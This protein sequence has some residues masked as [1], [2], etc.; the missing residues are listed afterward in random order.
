MEKST[1]LNLRVNPMVK[2]QAEN[3]LKQL[4]VPMAT[5]VDMFLRQITLTGGIPFDVSLPKAPATINA[6]TMTVEH[7]RA[8]LMAGYEDMRQ[9]NTQEAPD[10]FAKFREAHKGGGRFG[11]EGKGEDRNA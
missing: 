2:Q 10:A 6:D 5:A 11:R 4:G 9:G 8:E 3:V 7:L 1:T